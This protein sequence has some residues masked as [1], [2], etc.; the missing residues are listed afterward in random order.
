M[1]VE[2]IIVVDVVFLI[3]LLLL[4]EYQSEA[5]CKAASTEGK[6]YMWEVPH[7]AK[8]IIDRS[9]LELK[10]ECL[11]ALQAP[12]CIAASASRYKPKTAYPPPIGLMDGISLL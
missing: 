4:A 3:S 5:E 8:E 1:K 9:S 10:K 11:V 7:D 2:R 6:K 12:D